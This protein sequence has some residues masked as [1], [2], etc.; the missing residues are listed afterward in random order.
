MKQIA[1]IQGKNIAYT[2]SG[3]NDAP[4]VVLGH[5]LGVGGEIWGYQLPIL[6]DRYRVLVYDLP[7]HGESEALAKDCSLDELAS[8][9]AELLTHLGID[10]ITFVGLSIGGMIAQHFALLYPDRL[11]AVVLCSTGC[12]FDDQGRKIFEE[13]IARV[14]SEGIETQID[15]AVGRWFSEEFVRSAPATIA[16]VKNIFRKTTA[17]GFISCCRAIQ[18]L[19][20]LDRLSQ[21]TVPALLLPGERDQAFPPN[22]SRMMQERMRTAELA[23]LPGARHVGNVESAHAFNEILNKFLSRVVPEAL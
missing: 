14:E 10:R 19:N 8:D 18:K 17:A 16:W 13:R 23:V 4:V 11:Q 6:A 22:V 15:A 7:G 3:S 2:L 20:T 9:L 21:I 12:Q 5:P 1:V